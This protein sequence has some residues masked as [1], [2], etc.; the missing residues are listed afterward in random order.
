MGL[1][2]VFRGLG[3][4]AVPRLHAAE[5]TSNRPTRLAYSRLSEHG[6]VDRKPLRRHAPGHPQGASGNYIACVMEAAVASYAGCGLSLP[7]RSS[8]PARAAR[9]QAWTTTHGCC[10]SPFWKALRSFAFT[11]TPTVAINVV[12][13]TETGQACGRPC[14]C[15]SP[16]RSR[17]FATNPLPKGVMSYGEVG[18]TGSCAPSP[19]PVSASTK[20]TG[21]VFIR[22]MPDQEVDEELA[23]KMNLVRVKKSA[24]MVPCCNK[25]SSLKSVLRGGFSQGCEAHLC[26]RRPDVRNN[27]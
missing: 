25:Y 20:R 10:C 1:R 5:T 6:L 21:S 19:T 23:R 2:A 16:L 4:R 13:G 12:G 14:P 26:C 15:C 3:G 24:A 9:R 22:V 18:L 7:R 8:R 17:A 27:R 11:L